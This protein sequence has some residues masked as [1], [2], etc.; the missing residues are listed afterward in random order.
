MRH[1]KLARALFV[2]S[3]VSLTSATLSAQQEPPRRLDF[4]REEQDARQ[5]R[6]SARAVRDTARTPGETTREMRTAFVR[7][8]TILGLTAY[9]PAFATM[10]GDDGISATAG[11]MVMAG[12]SF[13]VATELTRQLEI[14]PAR[15]FLSSRMAWRGTINGLVIGDAVDLTGRRTA[16]LAWLGGIGGTATG[17]YVGR[18]LT[19]GEAVAMVVGHDIAYL[20]SLALFYIIDPNEDA[21]VDEG[22]SKQVRNLGS[23]AIGWAGYSLGRRYARRAPYEVTSGDALL[24]WL[25]SAIGATT[26]GAF[27]AEG[28]PS[29]QAVAGVTLAGAW[30]GLW[31]TDRWLVREYDHTPSEGALVALGGGAGALMGIGVGVLIA[32][33]AERG[34][35]LTMAFASAGAIGGV[36][37]TERYAQPAPD[38]GGALEVGRV[39]FNP[40]GAMALASRAEGMHPLLRITF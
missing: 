31:A 33:E 11:Y 13:F 4:T 32:G 2:L 35:S 19:E 6:D 22:M 9:G 30:A 15:Q 18:D 20:S 1:K 40:M 5:G 24:F 17:L 27:I 36:W 14:T 23:T 12:G 3:L 10:M 26:F 25:G 29:T 7:S 39:Q 8:Q 28:D 21:G 37:L 38:G 34:A 16:G